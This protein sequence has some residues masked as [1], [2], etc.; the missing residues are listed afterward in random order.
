[1]TRTAGVEAGSSVAVWGCGGVGLSAIQAAR[2]AGAETIVAVD[3]R[4]EKLELALRLGATATVEARPSADT[5]RRVRHA[6]SGGPDYAF[7]A[8]GRPETIREAWEAVRAGG[9]AVVLGLPPKGTSLTI[10][11]WGFIN[12]KTLK[13][14]F[15]GSARI[16]ED[17]P[18]LVDLYAEGK[19]AAGRARQRPASS[20]P[21]CRRPSSGSA[22]ARCSVSW[23][24]SADGGGSAAAPPAG[25]GA[26]RSGCGSA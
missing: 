2:L 15:L 18:R 20:S 4:P 17:V 12:E 9:T 6:T 10:D 24:S 13:G 26:R 5:G 21:G 16:Q 14:C 7:E 8:I 1:M 11:T 3:T 23:S 25:A 22:P 19:L